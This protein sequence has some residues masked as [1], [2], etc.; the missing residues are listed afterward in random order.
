M[1]HWSLIFSWFRT[2]KTT[3]PIVICEDLLPTQLV[4]LLQFST[5]PLISQV[6]SFF[7]K[8]HSHLLPPGSF[9]NWL[10]TSLSQYH[11][12]Q[13]PHHKAI[14]SFISKCSIPSH[15]FIFALNSPLHFLLLFCLSVFFVSF[16]SSSI[17][18]LW[19]KFY[20]QRDVVAVVAFIV[21]GLFCLH[22]YTIQLLFFPLATFFYIYCLFY[23][24]L[25]LF[26]HIVY[27][28]FINYHKLQFNKFSYAF[29]ARI[30]DSI[31]FSLRSSLN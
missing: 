13:S 23:I 24:L 4:C 8:S 11:V 18:S 29:I 9:Q 17:I 15:S 5:F 1:I 21:L 20:F 10:T 28:S 27:I 6:Y 3:L 31:Q 26:Y 12:L 19:S 16:S 22:F 25:L 7:W 14:I 30:L 2:W